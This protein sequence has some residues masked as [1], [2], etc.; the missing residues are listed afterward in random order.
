MSSTDTTTEAGGWTPRLVLSLVSMVLIIEATTLGYTVASIGLPKI[1]QEFPTDQAGW[2]LTSFI[3]AGAVASAIVGK[4]ADIFGK[5]RLMLF[6]LGIGL[7]G[8]LL[9]ALAPSF[10]IL[11]LARALQGMVLPTMFLSYSLMRDVY[12]PAILPMATA[13]S[14][15]GIGVFSVFVPFGAGW[16][17]DTFGWRGLF[18]FDVVWI[19]CLGPLLA[20]TTPESQVRVRARID[21]LGGA[22]LGIGLGVLL[23]GVSSA[24]TKGWTSGSTMGFLAVGMLMLAGFVARSL[25]YSAPIVDLRIFVRRGILLAALTAGSVY[26]ASAVHASLSP[27]IG[28]TSREIGGDYGLGL[29]AAE[30]GWVSAPQAIFMVIAGVVVGRTLNRF[31]AAALMKAG[32][33]IFTLGALQL[34]FNHDTYWQVLIGTVL[35]GAATG[36]AYGSIPGLVIVSA[37]AKQQAS[38]AGMVQVTYNSIASTAPIVAFAILAGHISFSSEAGAVY[39]SEGFKVGYL[40]TA[41]ITMAGLILALTVLRTRRKNLTLDA[42]RDESLEPPIAA[43]S[44]GAPTVRATD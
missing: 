32:L 26:A 34:A 16:L 28:M 13:I 44:Q 5:R 25:N 35:L 42:I 41:G 1:T 23:Y 8:A 22:L 37:P 3:L 4:L 17:L 10:G 6:C 33:A 20:I 9:A 29:S 24:G 12:P 40:F 43:A 27:M 19:L 36:L 2:L 31:G 39:S 7:L 38:I 21:F 30:Y 14:M 15:T 11:I 18:A